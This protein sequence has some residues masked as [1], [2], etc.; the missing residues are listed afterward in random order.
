MVQRAQATALTLRAIPKALQ[1]CVLL[2]VSLA[3]IIPLELVRVPAA[4]LLGAM[5]AAILLAVFEGSLAV[6]H[7][8]YVIAQGLIGCLVARSIG[9]AILATMIRQ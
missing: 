7:W 5:A 9:P 3:L 2:A 4:L 6:P 8:P 1:W